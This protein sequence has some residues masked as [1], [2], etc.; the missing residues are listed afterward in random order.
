MLLRG[1]PDMTIAPFAE[2]TKL[3]HFGMLMLDVVLDRQT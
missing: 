3:L 2:L 1:Y